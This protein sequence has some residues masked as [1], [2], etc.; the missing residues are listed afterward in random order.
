[1]AIGDTQVYLLCNTMEL[2]EKPAG[3]TL[4]CKK[5]V[6]F[7]WQAGKEKDKRIRERLWINFESNMQP[8]GIGEGG[9]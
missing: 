5:K 7:T 9:K 1:M 4:F 2:R 8:E 3:L 6:L